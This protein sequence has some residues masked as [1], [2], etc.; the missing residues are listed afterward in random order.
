MSDYKFNV[1][2][3]SIGD[4][5]TTID[6]QYIKVKV[7]HDPATTLSSLSTSIIKNNK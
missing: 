7:D 1:K 6:S 2:L 4:S 5:S 3:L